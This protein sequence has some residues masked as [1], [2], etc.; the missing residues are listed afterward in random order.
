MKYFYIFTRNRT[1][2]LVSLF[3]CFFIG[4]VL[5][6][7]Q[8]EV[9]CA[10][11][12]NPHASFNS[13]EYFYRSVLYRPKIRMSRLF[14]DKYSVRMEVVLQACTSFIVHN[15]NK[16]TNFQF[17]YRITQCIPF[18]LIQL[19]HLQ[20]LNISAIY[21][22]MFD[23]KSIKLQKEAFKSTS[24]FF[25]QN[26]SSRNRYSGY[27]GHNSYS[28]YTSKIVSINNANEKCTNRKPTRAISNNFSPKLRNT[29][30]AYIRFH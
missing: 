26:E 23:Y 18:K 2:S 5:C 9:A 27:A 3:K 24:S 6:N 11:V 20:S 21:T 10:F 4:N 30:R 25:Q 13:N 8:K 7:I 16:S 17:R 28:S 22:I 15:L 14:A 29:I 12:S 19:Y 1:F